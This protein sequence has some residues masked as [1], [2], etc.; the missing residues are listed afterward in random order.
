MVVPSAMIVTFVYPSS[1]HRTGGVTVLYEFANGLARRGHDVRFVHGPRTPHLVSDVGEIPFAFDDRITHHLVD[2]L[3]DPNIGSGDVVLS[4]AAPAQ[5]GLPCTFVQGYRMLTPEAERATYFAPAP[6]I[7]IARWLVDVGRELGVP[8]AQLWYVPLGLQHDV[9]VA[10]REQDERPVDV[11]MLF[12]PHRSKG[13]ATGLET[14]R[15]LHEQHPDLRSVVFGMR[16]PPDALP[17]GTTFVGAPTHEQLVD[18]VY[19]AAKVFVQ[20]SEVEGFGYTPVEAMACGAALVTT[21]NGGSRDY[22]L[23][24]ETALVAPTN[25]PAG[26]T[27]RVSRL[28]ADDAL[29]IRLADAGRHHVQGFDWDRSAELL[30]TRLL[31]Y[32]MDPERHGATTHPRTRDEAAS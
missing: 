2:A 1:S 10:R 22:G 31:E 19:N 25:D 3:D 9:F 5:L 28:L 30:E 23:D 12:H 17:D 20:A 29:R 11:A 13:W 4:T 16:H 18:Q 6:K 15:R 32:L 21:D 14:L 8:E 26:L 27:Q 24:G 7:C